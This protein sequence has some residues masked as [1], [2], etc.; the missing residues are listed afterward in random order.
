V[1]PNAHKVLQQ[2]ECLLL[3]GAEV[4]RQAGRSRNTVHD[5]PSLYFHL[6]NVQLFRLYIH[7]KVESS[8]NNLVPAAVIN[9]QWHIYGKRCTVDAATY[10]MGK[11]VQHL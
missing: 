11:K 4:K 1:A 9:T 10:I 2:H 8:S 7:P 6:K 3:V 5:P